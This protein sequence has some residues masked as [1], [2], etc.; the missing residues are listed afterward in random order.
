MVSTLSWYLLWCSTENVCQ[1]KKKNESL[2]S[3]HSCFLGI[4]RIR[5][6]MHLFF[7]DFC[8]KKKSV[9][10][11][12]H[13]PSRQPLLTAL[14]HLCARVRVRVRVCTSPGSQSAAGAAAGRG[15]HRRR[16]ELLPRATCR[17]FCRRLSVKI[18]GERIQPLQLQDLN[19]GE[20]SL[21]DCDKMVSV[22][23][24]CCDWIDGVLSTHVCA[25]ERIQ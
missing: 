6:R 20:F 17:L 19:V 23:A 8:H 14:T 21:T 4:Y 5:T 25:V 15:S 24:P 10:P 7:C 13:T 16:C 3:D 2:K 22:W 11:L 18:L 1:L 12:Q 9:F